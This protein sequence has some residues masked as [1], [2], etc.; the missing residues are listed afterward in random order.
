MKNIK[1]K[2]YKVLYDLNFN[3][4]ILE[5][6]SVVDG[7]LILREFEIDLINKNLFHGEVESKYN[8]LKSEFKLSRGVKF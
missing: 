7:L 2:N 6:K 3:V 1:L 4:K 8:L 5:D